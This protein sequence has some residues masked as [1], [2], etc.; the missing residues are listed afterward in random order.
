MS[1]SSR[2][3]FTLTEVLVVLGILAILAGLLL[4]AVRRVRVPAARMQCQNNLKQ[5]MLAVHTY[6]STGLPVESPPAVEGGRLV[7]LFPPG[8]F[9][10]GE[11]PEQRLSWMVALLPF[12]EHEDLYRQFDRTAGYDGNLPPAQ[13][14]VKVFTCPAGTSNPPEPMTHYVAL[15]GIG[16]AAAAQPE[17]AAGNGFMG[18]DRPTS[19]ASITDG[20]SNTIAVMETCRDLGPWARG[21]ASNL[22]GFDPADSLPVGE[23]RAFFGEHSAM[24]HAAMADGSVRTLLSSV[25]QKHL[26]AAVTI[27][28]E[29]PLDFDW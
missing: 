1:R 4:P 13:T 15:S 26:A 25:D 11:M 28:G 3:G 21:G 9:G 17:Y 7:P 14:P 27:A 29:E 22:R 24:T 19:F 23:N 20:T 12:L 16:H 8:C 18:D 5:L 2:S 10:P 6:E